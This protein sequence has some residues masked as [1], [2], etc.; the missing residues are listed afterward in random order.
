MR[1]LLLPLVLLVG[2]LLRPA[3]ANDVMYDIPSAGYDIRAAQD[4]IRAAMEAALEDDVGDDAGYLE[5]EEDDEYDEYDDED[6]SP[7]PRG[8]R[9]SGMGGGMG[10]GGMGGGGMGGG[11]MG[12]YGDDDDGW[13]DH[14]VEDLAAAGTVRGK[15]SGGIPKLDVSTLSRTPFSLYILPLV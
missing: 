1:P 15:V 14:S 4:L 6:E 5:G 11:G 3:C 9:G 13:G 12:G 10:G 7:P 8:G 2:L